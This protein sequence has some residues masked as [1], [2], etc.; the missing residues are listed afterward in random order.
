MKKKI[1]TILPLLEA[2][3]NLFLEE[4]E[5]CKKSGLPTW[6]YGA[7]EGAENVIKRTESV[8]IKFAG[9]LVDRAFFEAG[10]GYDCLEDVI[11]KEKI[12]LVVAHRGFDRRKLDGYVEH[13]GILV[14]RDCFS[15]NYGADPEFMTSDFVRE[16]D[17]E[18]TD[19][20]NT[21]SDERSRQTLLAYINQRISMDYRFLK[22]VKAGLQYFDAELIAL[23][24]NEA[25]VDAGAY[26][27]DTVENFLRELDRRGIK[28][29]DAVYSFEPDPQNYEKLITKKFE[30]FSAYNT[31]TSDKKEEVFFSSRGKGSSSGISNERSEHVIRTDAIDHILAGQ[32]VTF[33]KMDVEGYEL[34]S[35]KGAEQTIR[36]Q[37]PK[38]AVC[39][40]HKRRDLFEIQNYISSVLGEG[41]V[42][43]YMRAYE[44]TATELVL[45]ALPVEGERDKDG[46]S[47]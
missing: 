41:K 11:E 1:D 20:Y 25:L 36:S 12:N 28:T 27:G 19:V 8:G 47:N 44:E 16:H 43:F 46:T 30:N 31:A 22:P 38:L 26:I 13:I 35:L 2:E 40:Y 6:I 4:I 24:D 3:R 32:K 17:Q 29:Y 15:G 9:R 37:K 39:I 18:L 45:Y 10:N 5:A 21:L 34:V 33:I 42:K 7:G 23:S 14:D